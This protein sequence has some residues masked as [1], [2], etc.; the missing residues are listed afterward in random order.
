MTRKRRAVLTA[1]VVERAD[2]RVVERGDRA[3]FALEPLAELRVAGEVRRQ[4][5]DRDGAIETRVARLVDLAH[6]A[7]AERRH[8]FVRT[9]SRTGGERHDEVLG[10]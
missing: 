7:R 1:D 4:D 5:L 2:V 8:D 6:P 9:E 3:G 10:L